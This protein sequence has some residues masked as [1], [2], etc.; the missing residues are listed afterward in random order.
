[1]DI[2]RAREDLRK[3]K[4]IYDMQLRVV[5]YARVSTDKDD[6]L[7][8]LENQQNYFEEMITEN[9]NWVF[10]GGYIDEGISGTAVKNRERFL[11]MIEDATLGKIDMIVTKEISRFSRNTVDSIQYTQELLSYGVGINFINDN[12]NTFDSDSELRLTIM[13]SIAQEEVRKLSERVRFGY[14][15]SIEKGIVPGNDNFYG[16]KKNKGKLEIDGYEADDII[17]TFSSLITN[18]EDYEGLIISS[19]RDLLQLINDKVTVKLL[20]AKDYIMMNRQTFFDTY[21]IEPIKVIDLKGLEGDSSD[22]IPGVKG[23]GEKTAL[24]LLQEYGSLENIYVNLDKIKGKLQEKLELGK[25][26]AFMSKQLA[27][28]YKEVPT[29]LT[30]DDILYKGPS[31]ELRKMY[32]ELEFYS[33]IK[34]SYV[35]EQDSVDVKIIKDINE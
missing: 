35:P 9:K 7:N 4:T 5:Y 34:N 22:N 33:L 8:S 12:I 27:T 23:I 3:G 21:G 32:E 15:R 19:D 20:K 17:G 30:I 18:S 28:I 31:N 29:N 25:D 16:Y 11:K 1:M 2:K 6:Q 13:S 24:K 10:C 14:K 26:S